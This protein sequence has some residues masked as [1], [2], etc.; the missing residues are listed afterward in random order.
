[1]SVPPQHGS[2]RM[3]GLAGSTGRGREERPAGGS[4]GGGGGLSLSS[5]RK[6]H[7]SGHRRA[8]KPEPER[9][10]RSIRSC[11]RG[12]R[13]LGTAGLA[14]GPQGGSSVGVFVPL[15]SSCRRPRPSAPPPPPPSPI[16]L[17]A[18]GPRCFEW[19]LRDPCPG[20][21]WSGGLGQT[22]GGRLH[23]A[24]PG[25]ASGE[26]PVSRDSRGR[27]PALRGCC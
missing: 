15:R 2:D 13:G 4:S 23:T 25:D 21:D 5:W 16:L 18:D 11:S 19:R 6:C 17:A 3:H 14:A 8:D 22:A 20:C 24:K 26:T 7:I 1:M 12:G 10:Y 9:S 27:G